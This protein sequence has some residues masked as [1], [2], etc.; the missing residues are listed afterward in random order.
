MFLSKTR[1]IWSAILSIALVVYAM[2]FVSRN[3]QILSARTTG[4]I[5]FDYFF[6]IVLFFIALYLIISLLTWIYLKIS[7][8]D[9]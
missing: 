8:R 7:R 9:G 3:V 5:I 6:N 4:R 2:N 1:G